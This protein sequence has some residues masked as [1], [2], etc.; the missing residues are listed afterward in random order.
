MA[1]HVVAL[2]DDLVVGVG[3][4]HGQDLAHVQTRHLRLV[5]QGRRRVRQ[6]LLGAEHGILLASRAQ[7][8]ICSLRVCG[9]SQVLSLRSLL[10]L[11]KGQGLG[12]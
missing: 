9:L 6:D 12:E 3:L 2:L 8:H 7:L 10:L 11:P 1:D 5:P 4:S